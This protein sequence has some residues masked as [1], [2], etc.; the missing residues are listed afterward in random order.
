[1]VLTHDL[2]DETFLFSRVDCS[3]RKSIEALLQQK[4]IVLAHSVE[5]YS[6]EALKRCVM[7]GVG[8]AVL[9]QVAVAE[10]V[11]A[12][13]LAV[14]NWEEG[15]MEVAILMI[16]FQERWLSPALKQFMDMAKTVIQKA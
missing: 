16:W 4:Q 6:V 11:V 12:N 1:V 8:I 10:E 7:A 2:A 13:K 5:F 9:P 15:R 3:Y 14:L